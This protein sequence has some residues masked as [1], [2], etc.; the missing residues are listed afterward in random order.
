[1]LNAFF[2]PG[3]PDRTRT[4]TSKT[5]DPKSGASTNSATGALCGCKGKEYFRDMQIY[6]QFFASLL[7][8]QGSGSL[9]YGVSA[10]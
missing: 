5:P 8:Q 7:P 3:T 4:Y 10:T 2:V 1:M 9:D 6:V